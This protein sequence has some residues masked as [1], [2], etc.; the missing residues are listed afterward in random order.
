[1]RLFEDR[2]LRELLGPKRK[3]VNRRQERTAK[4]IAV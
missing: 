3:E 4:Y 1:M 2:V